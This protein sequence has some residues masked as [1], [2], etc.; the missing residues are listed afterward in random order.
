MIYLVRTPQLHNTGIYY[1]YEYNTNP[2][3]NYSQSNMTL[4]SIYSVGI[5]TVQAAGESEYV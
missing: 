3:D 5:Q 1:Q 2:L 4:Y